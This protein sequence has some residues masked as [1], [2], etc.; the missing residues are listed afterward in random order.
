LPKVILKKLATTG[1]GGSGLLVEL[2]SAAAA[3]AITC[4][5]VTVPRA[6]RI[7]EPKRVRRCAGTAIVTE[8]PLRGHEVRNMELDLLSVAMTILTEILPTYCCRNSA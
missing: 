3:G 5:N 7:F 2:H 4:A 8:F 1:D 6:S